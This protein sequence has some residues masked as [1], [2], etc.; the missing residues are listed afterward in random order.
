MQP[1]DARDTSSFLKGVNLDLFLVDG[2]DKVLVD[3]AEN[4]AVLF[5]SPEDVLV[6]IQEEKI[7]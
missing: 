5:Q 3:L 4:L 1:F 6:R 7:G 2:F